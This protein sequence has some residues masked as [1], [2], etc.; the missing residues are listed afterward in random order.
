[1]LY[2]CNG[3]GQTQATHRTPPDEMTRVMPESK[4]R[5]RIVKM[6]AGEAPPGIREA[7][8]DVELRPVC[9]I[10]QDKKAQGAL[11]GQ[12]SQTRDVYSVDQDHALRALQAKNSDAAQWW[13][14]KHF[15]KAGQTFVFGAD[16]VIELEPVSPRY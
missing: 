1:M 3:C 5:I 4:G 14:L 10:G 16:E 13:Y 6:P 15:P 2:D 9:F 11:S 7:W 12:R 8:I